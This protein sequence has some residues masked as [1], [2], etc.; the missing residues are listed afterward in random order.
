MDG[1]RSA[2]GRRVIP[3]SRRRVGCRSTGQLGYRTSLFSYTCCCG[4]I[5]AAGGNAQNALSFSLGESRSSL[6]PRDRTVSPL[7]AGQCPVL[8]EHSK[9]VGSSSVISPMPALGLR[10]MFATF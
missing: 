6:S 2:S 5:R 1:S 9:V 7:A 3:S 10:L 4:S 8:H